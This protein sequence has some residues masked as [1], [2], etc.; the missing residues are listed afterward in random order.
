MTL[1]KGTLGVYNVVFKG[2]F[3]CISNLRNLAH[4]IAVRARLLHSKSS[5][6]TISGLRARARFAVASLLAPWIGLVNPTYER[7]SARQC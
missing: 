6:N 3:G 2:G 4:D 5:K 7:L 1:P